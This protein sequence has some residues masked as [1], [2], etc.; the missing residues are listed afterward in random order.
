[1]LA[2][3]VCHSSQSVVF[4]SLTGIALKFKC[5]TAVDGVER[6]SVCFSLHSGYVLVGSQHGWK[7]CK[8]LAKSYG[9]S[10][11]TRK[12]QLP[13]NLRQQPGT[14]ISLHD[15]S[16][17]FLLDLLFESHDLGRSFVQLTFKRQYYAKHICGKKE[18]GL[19]EDESSRISFICS[20][21]CHLELLFHLSKN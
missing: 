14:W 3:E 17:L 12:I 1:M 8:T 7:Q 18:L 19:S 9:T 2:L 6:C 20:I 16:E 15:L 5:W 4:N 13:I 11:D 21:F 10:V